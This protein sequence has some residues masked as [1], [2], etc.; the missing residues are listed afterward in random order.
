[1]T[2]YF[3][4]FLQLVTLLT[5]ASI[6]SPQ[7]IAI[8]DFIIWLLII[9]IIGLPLYNVIG[10]FAI[11]VVI[12]FLIISLSLKT[13]Q[14]FTN[15]LSVCVP[16]III[17][18]TDYFSQIMEMYVLKK[19]LNSFI[20]HYDRLL[21][22]E[23]LASM[24][25]ILICCFIKSLIGK[26]RQ[27]L[28]LD[29]KYQSLILSFLLLTLVIFYFNIFLGQIQG[30]SPKHLILTGLLFFIYAVLL[31]LVVMTLIY[32]LN[33]DAKMKQ[34][35][36]LN[37]QLHEYTLQ[38]EQ[39]Y[40]NLNSFRHDYLNILLSL[41]E[42]IRQENIEIIKDV[43]Q[44]IIQPTKQLVKGND[45]ILGQLHKI[46]VVEIKSLLT[47]KIIKSQNS[48][49]EVRLEI[50]DPINSIYMDTFS[51]YRVFSILLDNA[52]EGA[53]TTNHPYISIIMI[54]DRD[55]QQIQI[56]NNCEDRKIDLQTIY[57]KGYSSKGKDRGIGLYNVHQLLEENKYIRLETSYESGVFIQT[58]ILQNEER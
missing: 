39:L 48:G 51:F 14:V 22:V 12:L 18:V 46:Q 5:G 41:E 6:L 27:F 32:I 56:E 47:A 24:L 50:E 7:K 11:F 36:I 16:L 34:E 1:M 4:L 43:Y 30:F 19:V 29:R 13:K 45:Y 49:I 42:G 55:A 2:L 35:R 21:T 28:T 10:F 23:L 26:F 52:I 33:K 9:T 15:I 40:T 17:V 37:Q 44:S 54:Q 3:I 38:I 25:S 58:L 57:T 31:G 8:K 53:S 20:V